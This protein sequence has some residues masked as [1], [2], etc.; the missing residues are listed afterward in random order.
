[1]DGFTSSTVYAYSDG[2]DYF[3]IYCESVLGDDFNVVEPS[4]IV[5]QQFVIE[6][7]GEE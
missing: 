4:P 5:A 1:V 2:D 6:W 3:T 7:V